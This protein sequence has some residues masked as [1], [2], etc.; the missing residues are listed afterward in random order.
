MKKT[1]ERIAESP[2][3]VEWLKLRKL[4]I[5][6]SDAGAILG[7]NKYVSPHEVFIDKTTDYTKDL[8]GNEAVYWGTVLEP[9]VAAEFEKRTGKRVHRVNAVLRSRAHPYMLANLDRAVS[10]ENAILECKT[11]NQYLTGEWDGEEVPPSYI[12]QC[13]HYMAVTGAELCYIACLVGGQRFVFK[14]IARDD[15]F[16]E[17]L[18][19]KEEEFWTQHVLKNSP[20][21]FTGMDCDSEYVSRTYAEGGG[22]SIMPTSAI[23][24][25]LDEY[26]E[27]C[28]KE[29]EIALQKERCAN[30]I[31]D[32][33]GEA[34]AIIDDT[35][36]VKWKSVTQRRIDTKKLKSEAPDIYDKYS[37][38]ASSRRFTV[39]ILRK[40]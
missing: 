28:K 40:D 32:Y 1:Y 6:G 8:V 7:F 31:K 2:A 23:R 4:G 39:K 11:A 25:T 30:I 10:G 38:A 18:T 9:I 34:E 19:R 37:A 27:I 24:L 5:G 17:Y 3:Y 22:G 16:I 14:E 12:C 21:D 29:K 26:S 35:Y 20:P 13:Q 36:D 15:E 33:M